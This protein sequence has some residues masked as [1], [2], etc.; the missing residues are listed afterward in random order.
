[1]SEQ[2]KEPCG[3]NE[4]INRR[5]ELLE[6]GQ[7][8]L[9]ADVGQCLTLLQN[10]T[11]YRAVSARLSQRVMETEEHFRARDTDPAP[12]EEEDITQ[13]IGSS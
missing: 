1:M 5:L 7:S 8:E 3:C 12:P 4:D 6:R 11:E 10:M 2:P 9:K 13:R